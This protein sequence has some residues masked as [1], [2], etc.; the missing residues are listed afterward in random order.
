MVLSANFTVQIV[1]CP[2]LA[3]SALAKNGAESGMV[4][5]GLVIDIHVTRKEVWP[6]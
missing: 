1:D 3:G 2:L 5:I 4:V 6:T